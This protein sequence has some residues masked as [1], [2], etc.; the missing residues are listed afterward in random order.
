MDSSVSYCAEAVGYS[1]RPFGNTITGTLPDFQESDIDY[2]PGR[3]NAI[4][5]SYC[6]VPETVRSQPDSLFLINQ[7]TTRARARARIRA[8]WFQVFAISHH[9]L[10]P[11]RPTVIIHTSTA[12]KL[13][14]LGRYVLVLLLV[15]T[16][17]LIDGTKRVKIETWFGLQYGCEY[18]LYQYL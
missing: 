17:V 13:D 11:I 2:R 18:I 16:L 9:S 8:R 6:I 4:R 5:G 10:I 12:T 3:Y 15:V 14:C 1:R 7:R